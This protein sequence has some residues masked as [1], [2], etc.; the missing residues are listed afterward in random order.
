MDWNKTYAASYRARKD[1]L[2]PI[3]EIDPIALKDLVGMESQ[4]KA[5]YENTL[6]F[7]QD[8]G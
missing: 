2:K 6:N 4:K 7:M 3:V 8:K 5:L 1:Y